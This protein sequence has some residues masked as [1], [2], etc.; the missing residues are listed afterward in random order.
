[1]IFSF[2]PG[3]DGVVRAAIARNV[4]SVWLS[5]ALR[6]GSRLPRI[7]TRLVR[8]GGFDREMATADGRAWADEWWRKTLESDE[9]D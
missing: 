7:P 9:L 6:A 5:R 1:M 4:H 2:F 8:D 3:F